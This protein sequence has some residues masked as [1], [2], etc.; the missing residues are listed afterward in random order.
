M[1]CGRLPFQETHP[2]RLIELILHAVPARPSSLNRHVLPPLDGVIMRALEK[3]P[4]RRYATA[5]QLGE[6]LEEVGYARQPW[7]D[8]AMAARTLARWIKSP[9]RVLGF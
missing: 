5:A 3:D 1:A 8:V 6:A 7:I 2:I 4:R 9:S